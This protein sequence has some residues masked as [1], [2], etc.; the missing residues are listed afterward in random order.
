MKEKNQEQ[1]NMKVNS[2]HIINSGYSCVSSL[3]N[4]SW[5]PKNCWGVAR[6][7]CYTCTILISPVWSGINFYPR[8][9]VHFHFILWDH[10]AASSYYIWAAV[11]LSFSFRTPSTSRSRVGSLRSYLFKQTVITSRELI[12]QPSDSNAGALTLY[13]SNG[14]SGI[15]F[16][17]YFSSRNSWFLFLRDNNRHLLLKPSWAT[18]LCLLSSTPVNQSSLWSCARPQPSGRA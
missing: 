4:S 8:I 17:S 2:C 18:L 6:A 16:H 15:L 3:L 5:F 9:L 1:R 12:S 14:C 13:L 10:G 11:N 7:S